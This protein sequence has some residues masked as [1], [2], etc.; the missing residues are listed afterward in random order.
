MPHLKTPNQWSTAV[1]GTVVGI[2]TIGGIIG[3]FLTVDS[4]TD[5]KIKTEITASEKRTIE[6]AARRHVEHE[7]NHDKIIQSQRMIEAQANIKIASLELAQ[8]EDEIDERREAGLDV[9]ERQKRAQD[10]LMEAIGIWERQMDDAR[11]KLTTV[12]RNAV[13]NP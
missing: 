7:I 1:K 3:M 8:V 11:D 5:D 9:T 6:Q 4:W 13:P 2:T 12:S 10:R